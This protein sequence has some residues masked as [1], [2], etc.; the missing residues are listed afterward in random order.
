NYK[1]FNQNKEK[2][3]YIDRVVI[4]SHYRRMGLGTR[5]YKYLD[6]AAAKDS[7][8]ICCEV[9]SI[10]LN[11]ISLNFHAKN[12]FIEVGEKNFGDHSVKYLE[13]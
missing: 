8:P 1:Y 10:P 9:N 6:E 3:L 5:A 13:K 11:Q 2:F 4:K 7:L 12:G